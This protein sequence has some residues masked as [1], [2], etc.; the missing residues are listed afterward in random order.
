MRRRDY[1]TGI[2]NCMYAVRGSNVKKRLN[3]AVKLSFK[4]SPEDRTLI[5][6]GNSGGVMQITDTRRSGIRQ[7]TLEIV[8]LPVSFL[9]DVLGWTQDSNGVLYEGLQPD[10]GISLYYETEN[11]GRP[12]RHQLYDCVVCAPNFDVSTITGRL[13]A[14]TRKLDIIINPY[15]N[16]YYRDINSDKYSRQIAR[17][18]NPTLFNSWFGTE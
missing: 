15:R 5:V 4:P 2:S 16:N 1:S 11:G 3:G 9:V 7:A 8:S 17:E 14:D 6:R 12:I 10:V 18:D 13:S